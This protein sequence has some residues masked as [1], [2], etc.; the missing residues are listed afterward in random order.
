MTTLTSAMS[1]ALSGLNATTRAAQVVSANLANALN[2][3]YGRRELELTAENQAF[4]GGVKIDGIRRIVDPVLLADR[5]NAGASAQ[6]DTQVSTTLNQLESLVGRVDEASS[7]SGHLRRFETALTF[8]E[9]NPASDIRQQD[10]VFAAKE[11]STKFNETQSAI[12]S[13]R[14]RADQAI[15]SAVET[16]NQSLSQIELL[17]EKIVSASVNGHDVSGLLD[18]R[19]ELIDTVSEL[20]PVRELPRKHGSVS[21]VT[22]KGALLLEQSAST[23]EFTRAHTIMPHMTVASGDLSILTV[24]DLTYDL[25]DPSDGMAGGRLEGLFK[26]RDDLTV[27]AQSQIDNLAFELATRFQSPTLD[28]SLTPA[29]PGLFTD[30][31]S[32]ADISNILGF[33]GRLEINELADPKNG[34]EARR[35]RDGMQSL[36]PSAAGETAII[37][38]MISALSI[39]QTTSAPSL[40]Q[41]GSIIDLASDIASNTASSSLLAERATTT[42]SAQY[43]ELQELMFAD[44]VDTDAELQR[45]LLIEKNYAA[46]AKLIETVEAMLDSLMRI[47]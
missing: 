17:N 10:A 35:I 15:F 46:N 31:G 37:S 32:L 38:E 26:T 47:G 33:A 23:V 7:I 42:S 19:Q 3:N 4:N 44:G 27:T 36:L 30:G 39:D 41:G 11:V 9:S 21:L 24:G 22:A 28:P 34:G 18:Q 29:D 14:E 40:T 5:R 2:E 1:A 8:L 6:H 25:A 45:L 20:V 43:G 16:L 13:I 12:K